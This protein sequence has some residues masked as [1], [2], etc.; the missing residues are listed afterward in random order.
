MNNNP[1]SDTIARTAKV[2]KEEI[3]GLLAAVEVYVKRD[4]AADQK[5]WQ[6][7]M[8]NVARDLKKSSRGH[9]RG[10]CSGVSGRSPGSLSSSEVGQVAASDAI[11]SARNGS[12]TAS[13]AL[14]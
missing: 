1:N 2:G 14:R 4:H 11:R 13:R 7:M 10:V 6:S 8:Q 3:M 12:G 9:G 5:L